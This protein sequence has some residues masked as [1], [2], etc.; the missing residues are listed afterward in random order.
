[1][2]LYP[3][4][5]NSLAALEKEKARLTQ[6]RYQMEREA[7][8]DLHNFKVPGLSSILPKSTSSEKKTGGWQSLLGGLIPGSAPLLN[9][10]EQLLPKAASGISETIK[11]KTT[12]L[13]TGAAVEVVGGYLKWKAIEL[14]FKGVRHLF[15]SRKKK[16][17]A[18]TP[19][20][21]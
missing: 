9:I 20:T 2:K 6:Q 14:G 4:R 21:S 15:A 16:K 1:M 7:Q 5:L 3:K 8:S 10:I 18:K 12:K 13:A 17:E 19:K 11:K